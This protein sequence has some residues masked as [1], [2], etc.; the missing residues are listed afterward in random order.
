MRLQSG[1]RVFLQMDILRMRE[2]RQRCFESSVAVL[3]PQLLHYS[4]SVEELYHQMRSSLYL[5]SL[6]FSLTDT[7]LPHIT[8]ITC[9]PITAK[10]FTKSFRPC[11]VTSLTSLCFC[12]PSGSWHGT[13]KSHHRWFSDRFRPFPTFLPVESPQFILLS[14]CLNS[15]NFNLWFYL[16]NRHSSIQDTG[17]LL[18]YE[19]MLKST[20]ITDSPSC[21]VMTPL[22]AFWI[23]SKLPFI[24]Q[25]C[26][27][28]SQ[29]SITRSTWIYSYYCDHGLFFLFIQTSILL[30]CSAQ[31]DNLFACWC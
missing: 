21:G 19:K 26:I 8:E 30:V 7:E 28:W 22:A 4:P 11:A 9:T 23:L 13:K 6:L 25:I 14:F 17:A 15:P 2:C 1:K 3:L 20:R 16:P 29:R 10:Y 31:T 5:F 18:F 24:I 12:W 27:D